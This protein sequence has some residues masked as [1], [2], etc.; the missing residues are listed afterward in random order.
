MTRSKASFYHQRYLPLDVH[1]LRVVCPLP[2]TSHCFTPGWPKPPVGPRPKHRRGLLKVP[3]DPGSA[4]GWGWQVPPCQLSGRAA[5]SIA[6]A[7]L[8]S[9]ILS[10][11]C[12]SFTLLFYCKLSKAGNSGCLF[13]FVILKRFFKVAIKVL[14]QRCS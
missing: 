11:G 14:W 4:V 1:G 9:R 8:I 10:P 2:A 6:W 7:T 3:S 12:W 5:D 13:T